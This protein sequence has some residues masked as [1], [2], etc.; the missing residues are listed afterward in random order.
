[1]EGWLSLL[2]TDVDR[3]AIS[4][5]SLGTYF[6]QLPNLILGQ[7]GSKREPLRAYAVVHRCQVVVLTFAALGEGGILRPFCL[8][9]LVSV[10]RVLRADERTRT[11]YPCSLRVCG[12]WL[13]GIAGVCK[14]RISK[15]FVIPR[16]AHYCRGLRP[17]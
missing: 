15:R 4:R 5:Q 10:Q 6:V 11:A 2:L 16:I 13:L 12:Q 14:L 17:G 9:V 8:D 1:M 3:H 7:Q